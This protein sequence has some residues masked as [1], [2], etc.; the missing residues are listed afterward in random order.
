MFAQIGMR[1]SDDSLSERN[2][3]AAA[4]RTLLDARLDWQA[5]LAA[6]A[7]WRAAPGSSSLCPAAAEALLSVGVNPVVD[8]ILSALVSRGVAPGHKL[9][10]A[11]LLAGEPLL[12]CSSH[13]FTHSPQR[14]LIFPARV[15]RLEVAWHDVGS[16]QQAMQRRT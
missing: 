3:H 5:R 14:N 8:V 9:E 7:G 6:G 13:P 11:K 1:A 10:A 4:V 2:D 15:H 12:P 16:C